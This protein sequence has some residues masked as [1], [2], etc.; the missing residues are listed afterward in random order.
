M[1]LP[2]VGPNAIEILDDPNRTD[3]P[4]DIIKDGNEHFVNVE[5]DSCDTIGG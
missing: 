4:C 1:F 3:D 2:T 5:I